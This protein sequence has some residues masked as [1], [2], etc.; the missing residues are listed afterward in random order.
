[1]QTPY[2]KFLQTKKGLRAV[3]QQENGR[4]LCRIFQGQTTDVP[5]LIAENTLP[6]FSLCSYREYTYLLYTSAQ[7]EVILSASKDLYRWEPRTL[8]RQERPAPTYY[9]MAPQ[10]DALHLIYHQPMGNTG[11]HSLMYTV[12]QQG[13]CQKPY[14]IDHFLPSPPE[15]F[16]AKRLGENHLILYYRSAKTT[17]SAR[18]L[19]LS[20]FTVGSLSPLIQTSS[21]WLDVSVHDHGE[22]IHVLYLARNLFRTQVLYRY[23]QT[24]SISR[25]RL[26]WEGVGCSSCLLTQ[27]QERV[28]LLWTAGGETFRCLSADNGHT[29]GPV[30]SMT[31]EFPYPLEKGQLV[32]EDTA[33]FAEETLGNKEW[34]YLP[35]NISTASA[36][37][38]AAAESGPSAAELAHLLAQQKEELSQWKQK[39]AQLE[40]RLSALHQENLHLR[41]RTTPPEEPS[42]PTAEEP[43]VET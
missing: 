40:S 37:R 27:E 11:L 36:D 20:P 10:Q 1:M 19:L 22:K 28:C 17:L 6:Y 26:I 35:K 32:T 43:T 23:R 42:E 33:F 29:F 18:E 30:E 7:G 41:E 16:R 9:F 25:P 3:F 8:F 34:Y 31:E 39:A 38:I 5:I 24:A 14:C 4:L 13:Q 2:L 12:F 15:I 21:P